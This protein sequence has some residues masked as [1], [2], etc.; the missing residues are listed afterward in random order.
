MFQAISVLVALV[1]F[2]GAAKAQDAKDSLVIAF[3]AEPTT[4]D[5]AR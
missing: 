2:A 5:P 1:V 3:G 4:L